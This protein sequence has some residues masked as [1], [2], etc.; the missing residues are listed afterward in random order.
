MIPAG[1]AA[2]AALLI[3]GAVALTV[4]WSV[5]GIRREGA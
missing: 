3:L 4:L 5:L 2:A 1:L